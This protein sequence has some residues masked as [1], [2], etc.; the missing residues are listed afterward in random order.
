MGAEYLADPNFADR[1]VGPNRDHRAGNVDARVVAGG[2]QQWHHDDRPGDVHHGVPDR[3]RRDLEVRRSGRQPG[4]QRP[5]SAEQRPDGRDAVPVPGAVR[6]PDECRSAGSRRAVGLRHDVHA[7]PA[8]S[9]E[10]GRPAAR[11]VRSTLFALYVAR[12]ILGF[13]AAQVPAPP[14]ADVARDVA[15]GVA[16]RAA[17]HA[18]LLEATVYCEQA[19]SPGFRALGSRGAGVVLV[20][21]S[22]EQLA[23]ARGA[24]P[25]FSLPGADLLDLLPTGYDLLLDAGGG[26]PLRL[27][28]AALRRGVSLHLERARP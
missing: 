4:P 13:M 26:A 17:L 23:L 5:H 22:P 11:F 9:D 28:P 27:R 20:F 14:L 18:A 19:P 10:G 1:R 24:V 16:G 8:A 6:H 7:T 12:S 25:W 21:S 2:Q 3:G 15:S